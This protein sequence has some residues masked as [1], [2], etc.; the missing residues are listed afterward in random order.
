MTPLQHHVPPLLLAVFWFNVIL[1]WVFNLL[2]LIAGNEATD[3]QF[4]ISIFGLVFA[5]VGAAHGFYI[6]F[7]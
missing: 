3:V 1:G 6:A 4:W 2:W 5:P 7:S